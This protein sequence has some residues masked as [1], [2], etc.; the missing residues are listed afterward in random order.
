MMDAYANLATGNTFWL[1]SCPILMMQF[2]AAEEEI[3]FNQIENLS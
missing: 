3:E 2:E 1:V